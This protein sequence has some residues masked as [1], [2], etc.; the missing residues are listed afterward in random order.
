[1]PELPEVQTVVDYLNTKITG[2]KI[3][4][5]NILA[6]KMVKNVLVNDFKN[7]LKNST[8][9]R[10][11]RF[12]KYLIFFLNNDYAMVS[13]L[14]MEGKYL[15]KSLG[16]T[17]DD[18]HI[19]LMFELEEMNLCYHDTRKFGTFTIYKKSELMSSLELIK[20]AIDPLND[21]F[22][23]KY[24]YSKIHKSKKAIK[25]ILLDQ[26]IVS[27]IGNIY[28]CEILFS[29]KVS[30]FKLGGEITINECKLIV[31]E[32]K[33]ILKLA[34]ENKGTTVSTFSFDGNHLGMF[35]NYLNVYNKK[36]KP[37]NKCN[38]MITKIP[39]NKRGTYYCH[40]CQK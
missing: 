13:H 19:H 6:E 39:I 35:Q 8:I 36:G 2:Q 32:S 7:Y 1:M 9:E 3:I 24:L 14:R 29:A 34:I 18:K 4:N 17:I 5:V 27:G 16:D 21:L 28:A 33:R 37:C 31:I 22:D 11:E 26:S 20:I 30:P 15:I 38:T 23:Y 10:V 25:T 12:G 40:N